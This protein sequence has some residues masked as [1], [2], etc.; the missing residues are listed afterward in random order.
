MHIYIRLNRNIFTVLPV[1]A[2]LKTYS[3]I[4]LSEPLFLFSWSTLLHNIILDSNGF[5]GKENVL[6]KLYNKINF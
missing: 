1:V 4:T 6:N 3:F 2:S 5:P